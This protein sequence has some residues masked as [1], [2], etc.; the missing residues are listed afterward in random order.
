[1][2]ARSI[3]ISLLLMLL[4]AMGCAPNLVGELRPSEY[5]FD[6]S[7]D[8]GILVVETDSNTPIHQLV[9][10]HDGRSGRDVHL[11]Q[12]E[13]GRRINFLVLS[14]GRYRWS[15]IELLGSTFRGVHYPYVWE[16]DDESDHWRFS[17]EPGVINYPGVIVVD[18]ERV[19]WLS[20]YTENRSGRFVEYLWQ[21]ADFLLDDF[22]L[23][24][25][26]R[27]RDDF[28]EFYSSRLAQ[29]REDRHRDP[30]NEPPVQ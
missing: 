24:Y 25:S 23:V 6:L 16:L 22:R 9:F 30:G 5:A 1:M 8:E 17:V 2:P 10:E 18:S 29:Q 11:R 26:G 15:R 3:E 4:V 20:A 27:V 14:A 21:D 13:K 7:E 19:G 12:I 28:L